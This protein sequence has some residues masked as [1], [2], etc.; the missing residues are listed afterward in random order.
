M[1]EPALQIAT[2]FIRVA[3]GDLDMRWRP[4][5]EVALRC[6]G[7]NLA[8]LYNALAFCEVQRSNKSEAEGVF[9]EVTGITTENVR[10]TTKIWVNYDQG[11]FRVEEIA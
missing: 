9:L 7:L 6:R 1:A 5:V 4:S 11:F 10:L 8:D 2:D 3:V